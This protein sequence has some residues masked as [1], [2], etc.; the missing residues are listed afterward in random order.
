MKQIFNL[1]MQINKMLPGVWPPAAFGLCLAAAWGS[2]ACLLFLCNQRVDKHGGM[3][4]HCSTLFHIFSQNSMTHYEDF[5]MDF[6][7]YFKIVS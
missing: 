3:G 5:N 6:G 4:F 2:F 7:V 1:Q